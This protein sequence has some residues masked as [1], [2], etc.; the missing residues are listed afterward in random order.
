MHIERFVLY[1]N[2][3]QGSLPKFLYRKFETHNI[4]FTP[5]V[6]MCKHVFRQGKCLPKSF[7]KTISQL[8]INDPARYDIMDS[9]NTTVSNIKRN[10]I[11]CLITRHGGRSEKSIF[12][13]DRYPVLIFQ[14]Q[15]LRFVTIIGEKTDFRPFK[16]IIVMRSGT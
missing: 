16:L 15:A 1:R 6:N 9:R 12:T 13:I 4:F 8:I 11:M 3:L 10:A 5:T 7:T 2:K 14:Q